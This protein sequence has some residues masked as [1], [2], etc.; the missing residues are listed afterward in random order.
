MAYDYV[1]HTHTV[2]LNKH[3]R[4]KIWANKCGKRSNQKKKNNKTVTHNIGE[5]IKGSIMR[6]FKRIIQKLIKIVEMTTTLHHI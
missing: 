2:A 3:N 6:L 4:H 5:F 1:W